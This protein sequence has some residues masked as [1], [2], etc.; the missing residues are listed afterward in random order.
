MSCQPCLRPLW[1]QLT[2][3]AGKLTLIDAWQLSLAS[4]LL[5]PGQ[6]MH[7]FT[8][9]L[10]RILA[11]PTS[12]HM[13]SCCFA[14]GVWLGCCQQLTLQHAACLEPCCNILSTVNLTLVLL[15]DPQA[16]TTDSQDVSAHRNASGACDCGSSAALRERLRCHGCWK[17]NAAKDRPAARLR[18]H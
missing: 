10:T 2:N 1:Q 8:Q 13:D 14:L 5:S 3:P 6:L 11:K 4:H 16:V 18:S 17:V 9:T 15:A 7:A 12:M